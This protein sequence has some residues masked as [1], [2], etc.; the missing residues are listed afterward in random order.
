[1]KLQ[2]LTYQQLKQHITKEQTLDNYYEHLL[3]NAEAIILDISIRGQ[4]PVAK[5]IGMTQGKLSAL[6]VLLK[7]YYNLHLNKVA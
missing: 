6:T 4:G 3:L 7:A 5:D 1:M 2:P